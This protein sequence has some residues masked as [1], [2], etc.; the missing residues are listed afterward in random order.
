MSFVRWGSVILLALIADSAVTQLEIPAGPRYE[1]VATLLALKGAPTYACEATLLS[2]PPAGCS[3]VLVRGVDIN[4]VPGVT[5][6]QNGTMET[7]P[8]QLVGVWNGLALTLTQPARPAKDTPGVDYPACPTTSPAVE[9]QGLQ[10]EQYVVQTWKGLEK[11]GIQLISVWPCGEKLDM[12]VSVADAQT[13][14]Y[15][16]RTY[17]PVNVFGWLSPVE[18]LVSRQV[19]G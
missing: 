2:L 4:Q 8:L 7:G 9:A 13:I 15:L 6:Y 14:D 18:G 10:R 5:R 3:G 11:R 1:V 12:E 17:G 16:T 19:S